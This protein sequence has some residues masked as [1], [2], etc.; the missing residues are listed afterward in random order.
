MQSSQERRPLLVGDVAE[1]QKTDHITAA[2]MGWIRQNQWIVLAVASGACA[3]F[4]GVFAKLYVQRR[5]SCFAPPLLEASH[6]GL[7]PGCDLVSIQSLGGSDRAT[8]PQL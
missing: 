3:A 2:E 4:N 8:T 6:R 7:P 5:P 1:A